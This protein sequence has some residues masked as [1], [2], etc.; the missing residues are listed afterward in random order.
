MHPGPWPRL[1]AGA[2]DLESGFGMLQAFQ[3]IA[4]S[5][6]FHIAIP[7]WLY[8]LHVTGVA[9][10]T[11]QCALQLIAPGSRRR[12]T[13]PRWHRCGPDPTGRLDLPSPVPMPFQSF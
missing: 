5:H 4:V 1:L 2:S 3:I 6:A 9:N 8:S 11:K 7:C 10:P 12:R 13:E